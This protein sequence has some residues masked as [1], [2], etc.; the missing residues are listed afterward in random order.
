MSIQTQFD[1]AIE[2]GYPP[3]QVRRALR[4]K[5]FIRAG[6]FIVHLFDSNLD[7]VMEDGSVQ[8][9]EKKHAVLKED[10]TVTE[11]LKQLSLRRETE[12][13]YHQ[14]KC[15]RCHTRDR[16][17]VCLPCSHLSL[18]RQCALCVTT[19]PMMDCNE[20]IVRTVIIY[21]A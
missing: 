9:E 7:E 15:L 17:I 5:A 4:Q 1:I 8:N 3:L 20:L 18:C 13:L 19:C 21:L 10:I 14:S 11:R 16:D 2:F 6:D 12:Q